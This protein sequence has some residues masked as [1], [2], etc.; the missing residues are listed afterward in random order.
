MWA[1]VKADVKA[2]LITV[3]KSSLD[4][5]IGDGLSF[6]ADDHIWFL[7]SSKDNTHRFKEMIKQKKG[8]KI[9]C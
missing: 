5:E 6:T 9:V 1:Q 2:G 8:R 3:A 7:I 4:A